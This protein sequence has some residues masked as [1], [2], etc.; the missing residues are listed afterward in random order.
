MVNS[1]FLKVVKREWLR[2]TSRRIYFVASVLLP[3]F[4]I[5]FMGTIFGGGQME[6]L[7]VGIVDEDNSSMSREIIRDVD[8]S[9]TLKVTKH[10]ATNNEALADVRRKNIYGYL[11][12][13][14]S[15]QDK[16]MDG[17]QVSL[18]Y[19]YHFAM[20]SVGDE[21][22]GTFQA[23]TKLISVSPIVTTAVGEGVQ[24]NTITAFLLPIQ[25]KVYPL[26]NPDMDYS[27]YL[28]Q[29]FFFVFIQILLLLVVT[30]AMGSE[31]KFH[32]TKEWLDAAG[33]NIFIA[34]TGKLLIYVIIFIVMS[35]LS[36]YIYFGVMHIP[37]Q[38]GFLSINIVSALFVI[39]TAAMGVFL[40]SLFPALSVIISIV[41]MVGSLGATLSGVTFPVKSMFPFVDMF[42]YILP[43]RHF[44]E[45]CHSILYGN[46]GFS[47][48]WLNIVILL[49]FIIPPLLLLP[50]L[51]K[52]LISGKYDNIE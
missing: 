13:P 37:M 50:H 1:P 33:G 20:I 4:S 40:F 49:I 10:Y 7:P 16:V 48:Y 42:T 9:P 29:P 44:V 41:S 46:Y 15:F 2:M 52:T 25:S 51:K 3:L 38:S 34:V 36:N 17:K 45:I 43:I 22:K 26:F 24:G 21:I 14:P 12:I 31:S 19:Y 35:I 11:Y 6:A 28:T 32:T 27:I 30:Y 23:L 18:N 39:S 8:A 5:F 47:Y